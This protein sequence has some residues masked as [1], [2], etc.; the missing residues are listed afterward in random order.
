MRYHYFI[1]GDGYLSSTSFRS[2]DHLDNRIKSSLI[3]DTCD[4]SR[5]FDFVSVFYLKIIEWLLL[6]KASLSGNLVVD[7]LYADSK[8][9]YSEQSEDAKQCTPGGAG[10]LP[11][12]EEN[13]NSR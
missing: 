4:N 13:I 7:N 12:V 5:L 9:A 8:K 2:K 10:R 11:E 3:T 1:N 6:T